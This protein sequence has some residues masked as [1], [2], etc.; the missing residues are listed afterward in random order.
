MILFISL[1]GLLIGTTAL[2]TPHI[3]YTPLTNQGPAGIGQTYSPSQMTIRFLIESVYL[4]S[5]AEQPQCFDVLASNA[6]RQVLVNSPAR[7]I[8]AAEVKQIKLSST[9]SLLASL[10]DDDPVYIAT[11]DVYAQ[12]ADG[13]ATLLTLTL[14]DYGLLTPW[15]VHRYGDG[16]KPETLCYKTG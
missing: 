13:Q 1:L 14:W 12:T 4:P 9:T 3:T 7:K 10:L 5:A 15:S 11:A 6:P 2:F 16:W 8:V